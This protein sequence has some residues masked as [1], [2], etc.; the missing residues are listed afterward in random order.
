MKMI[1]IL[2]ALLGMVA[3]TPG[4]GTLLFA[5]YVNGI[6]LAPIFGAEPTDPTAQKHGQSL[7]GIPSGSTVY[8]GPLLSGPGF[9]VA[10]Y[11]GPLGTPAESLQLAAT[12]TF[13]TATINDLPAGLWLPSVISIPGLA[14]GERVTVDV[15]VWDNQ[16]GT[17]TTWQQVLQNAL[18]ARGSSGAFSPLG[19]LGTLSSSFT[20]SPLILVGLT[21]FNLGTVVPEPAVFALLGLGLLLF[22]RRKFA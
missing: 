7:L 3:R 20:D 19:L 17:I 18:I 21:S 15:R 9:T 16:G 6:L 22:F 8:S 4:Q 2:F 12:S 13:R 14:A 10:L 5:N 1:L 11:A